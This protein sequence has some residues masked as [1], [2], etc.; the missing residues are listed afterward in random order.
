MT[1]QL[2]YTILVGA[3]LLWAL[4]ATLRALPR[5]AAYR[6]P[7]YWLNLCVT[8]A[9]LIT[10]GLGVAR[11]FGAATPPNTILYA[12]EFAL[13]LVACTQI[14]VPFIDRDEARLLHKENTSHEA[15]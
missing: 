11:Q 8:V 1:I 12:L 3:M 2:G 13:F 14:A 6:K 10:F 15:V 4:V 5:V 9:L 7:V